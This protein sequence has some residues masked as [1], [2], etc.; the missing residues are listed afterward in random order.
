[1]RAAQEALEIAYREKWRSMNQGVQA[2]F[3]VYRISSDN[4]KALKIYLS[5]FTPDERKILFDAYRNGVKIW[6]PQETMNVLPELKVNLEGDIE[7]VLEGFLSPEQ[8]EFVAR[9]IALP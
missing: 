8:G 7:I 4:F 3:D 1:M 5:G 2:F 6:T 9:I